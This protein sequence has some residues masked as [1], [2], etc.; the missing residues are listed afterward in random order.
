MS[1]DELPLGEGPFCEAGCSHQQPQMREACA[2]YAAFNCVTLPDVCDFAELDDDLELEL[3][4]DG[5]E[6]DGDEVYEEEEPAVDQAGPQDDGGCGGGSPQRR[7]G[8]AE[9]CES[10]R[11]SGRKGLQGT[12]LKNCMPSV[13]GMCSCR[14]LLVCCAS[15]KLLH[16]CAHTH[17]TPLVCPAG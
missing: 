17:P 6:G 1:D 10:T 12:L 5:D 9:V 3:D 8:A 7:Q 13:A 4:Y 15:S 2:S 14:V 11:Y 16:G